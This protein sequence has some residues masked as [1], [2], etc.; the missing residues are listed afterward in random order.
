MCH[1]CVEGIMVSLETLK[2]ILSTIWRTDYEG[3]RLVYF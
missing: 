3:I 1:S 2:T